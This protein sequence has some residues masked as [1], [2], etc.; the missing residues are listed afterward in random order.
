ML[1]PVKRPKR[2]SAAR[3]C[4]NA[5]PARDGFLESRESPECRAHGAADENL[6][7]RVLSAPVGTALPAALQAA[8]ERKPDVSVPK[9]FARE[10][11]AEAVRLPQKPVPAEATYARSIAFAAAAVLVVALF[12]LAPRAP[13]S[14]ASLRFDVEL[15]LLLQLAVLAWWL[16]RSPDREF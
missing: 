1:D 15:A 16:A 14:F 12:A 7:A 8:L 6:P 11:A 2:S 9:A 10:V 3:P 4:E 5:G 13:A